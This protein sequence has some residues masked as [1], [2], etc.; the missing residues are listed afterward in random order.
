MVY[1]ASAFDIDAAGVVVF[2]IVSVTSVAVMNLVWGFVGDR[3][4]HK[5]VLTLAA[6]CLTAAAAIAVMAPDSRMLAAT[7]VLLGAYTAG[8]GVSGLN[9]I[10][11]FCAPQDRPTYIGLTN[12]L[13]APV[14]TVAPIIGALLASQLGYRP[15]FAFAMCVSAF[16][17]VLLWRWV[18]EPRGRLH[19]T[20]IE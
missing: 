5:L 12:T 13:L 18:R 4:G 3:L 11:E 20:I 7:F 6:F 2:T 1:G 16:G 15:M 17:A 8:D 10:L 19:A 9:I 14:V